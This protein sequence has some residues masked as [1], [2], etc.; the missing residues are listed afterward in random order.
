MLDKLH[1][2]VAEACLSYVDQI[3]AEACLSYW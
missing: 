2:I 3:V 1:Q